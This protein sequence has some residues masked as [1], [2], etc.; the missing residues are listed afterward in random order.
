MVLITQRNSW[1]FLILGW[2]NSAELLAGKGLSKEREEADVDL[3][4][5]S[6]ISS[7]EKKSKAVSFYFWPVCQ[8]DVLNWVQFDP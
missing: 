2:A 1:R 6:F 8:Q 3:C 4:D 5:L 7:L